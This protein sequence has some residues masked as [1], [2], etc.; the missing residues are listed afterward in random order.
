MKWNLENGKIL[1]IY[2]YFINNIKYYDSRNWNE[3]SV[4]CLTQFHLHVQISYQVSTDCLFKQHNTELDA[5]GFL[6][7]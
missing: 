4:M 2:I 7:A 1:M 3:V 5:W 6:L